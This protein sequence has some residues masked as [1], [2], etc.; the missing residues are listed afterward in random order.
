MVIAIFGLIL[1]LAFLPQ[2]I[3]AFSSLKAADKSQADI[4]EEK[5]EE[6]L[7]QDKGALNNTLDTIFGEGTAESLGTF[8]KSDEEDTLE[9]LN[10]SAS[11]ALGRKVTFADDTVINA[12]GTISGQS[13]FELSEK[14]IEDI[15]KFRNET[16]STEG[17]IALLNKQKFQKRSF[18]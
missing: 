4:A 16:F 8:V 11:E 2:I 5:K 9:K 7:R 3:S 13:F 12:D 17:Q 6:S 18:A 10:K 14:D 15:R 1:L